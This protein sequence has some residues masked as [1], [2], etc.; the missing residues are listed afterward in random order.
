MK[1]ITCALSVILSL[2]TGCHPQEEHFEINGKITEAQ[3]KMLYFEASTLNGI[4]PLDSVRLDAAGNFS[5]RNARPLNPEFYRLRIERQIINLSVDSTEIIHIEA[6]Q[7]SMGTDY[8]IEGSSDCQTIKEISNKLTALQQSIQNIA[9]NTQLTLGEQERMANELVSR[10]KEEMKRDYILKDPSVPSA[11]FALFQTI[12]GRLIFNPVNDPQDVKFV[13]AV[14][15]AWE[16]LYPNTERTENLRNIALQGMRNTKRPDPI[17]L[18]DIDPNKISAAGIIEIELPDIHGRN[19][20]LSDLKGK[21]VLLD[22]TAYSLPQS[23]ERIMQM[24]VLYDK[25]ASSGLEIYQVSIDPDEHYWKTACEHLPWICVYESEG[26]ASAY[27]GSYMVQHLPT[28]FLIDRHSNLIARDE[29][30]TD[31][32]AAVESLCTQ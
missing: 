26:E 13:G 22:F 6:S 4:E 1:R 20:K 30:I 8:T 15:T 17:S 5:F 18:K 25:Y 19:R 23:Q 29:Q 12:G 24:R 28:F 10:Y 21:V 27:L 14:A 3:D 7:P 16:A 9:Q 31:L 2:L 32:N 11:Y